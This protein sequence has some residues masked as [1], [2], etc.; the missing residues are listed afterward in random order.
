MLIAAW[1]PNLFR[2][3]LMMLRMTS[4]TSALAPSKCAIASWKCSLARWYFV[5][6]KGIT[7]IFLL[8]STPNSAPSPSIALTKPPAVFSAALLD[9]SPMVRGALPASPA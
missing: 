9:A 3:A 5:S 8:M 6:S 7:P 4:A 1:L 2:T